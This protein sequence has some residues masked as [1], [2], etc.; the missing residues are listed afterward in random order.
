[1]ETP[2]K[3]DLA[4]AAGLFDGEGSVGFYKYPGHGGSQFKL[5]I[6]QYHPEVLIR[7]HR[8]VGGI[9][10]VVGPRIGHNGK[11]RWD[12]RATSFQNVQAVIAMIWPWLSS[13]KRN[14][15]TKAFLAWQD[16]FTNYD[17]DEILNG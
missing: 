11:D 4:W 10:K 13:P 2:A 1:M 12:F 8:A 5:N 6:T 17:W 14:Q 7:F 15:Y 3:E 9:G 16:R